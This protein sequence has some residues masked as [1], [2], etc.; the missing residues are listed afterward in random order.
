MILQSR[1]LPERF[2]DV[3]TII[4]ASSDA[5]FRRL[6]GQFVELYAANPLDPLEASR[7]FGGTMP[8]SREC[9]FKV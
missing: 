9:R 3:F 8:S 5:P 7:Q 6:T 2:G 1:A 4:M